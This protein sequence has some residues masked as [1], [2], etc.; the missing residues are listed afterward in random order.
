MD[1]TLAII[2]IGSLGG[3]SLFLAIKLFTLNSKNK[4]ALWSC[5]LLQVVLQIY[6]TVLHE[7]QQRFDRLQRAY[8]DF[9]NRVAEATE[10]RRV[11]I[12]LTA[13]LN[14]IPGANLIGILGDVL[15]VF[16]E[17]IDAADVVGDAADSPELKDLEVVHDELKPL[18][19]SPEKARDLLRVLGGGNVL[20]DPQALAPD[21]FEDFIGEVIK[22]VDELKRSV[23]VPQRKKIIIRIAAKF[24]EFG[25]E[26][27][28]SKETVGAPQAGNPSD[29]REKEEEDR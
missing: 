26:F 3:L 16:G 2:L 5:Y 29:S 24:G 23:T 6:I 12:G 27:K 8:D 15:D 13:L 10:R 28:H 7:E 9:A 22:G 20:K 17:T 14:L 18:Y 11:R 19:V 25:I 1:L 21:T 4:N